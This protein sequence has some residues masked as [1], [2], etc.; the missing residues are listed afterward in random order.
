MAESFFVEPAVD[1]PIAAPAV[2][3]SSVRVDA[4]AG[5]VH[6]DSQSIHRS[7]SLFITPIRLASNPVNDPNIAARLF[8]LTEAVCQFSLYQNFSV[9][10]SHP[11]FINLAKRDQPALHFF[12]SD[13]CISASSLV[14][15]D[16]RF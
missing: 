3:N 13:A 11:I 9:G 7:H 16:P 15:F 10:D 2:E 14:D 12:K 1:G 6:V 8:F 4:R 5:R